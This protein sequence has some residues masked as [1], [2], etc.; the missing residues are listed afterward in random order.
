M[1]VFSPEDKGGADSSEFPEGLLSAMAVSL[2]ILLL[3][4][5]LLNVLR[6]R[7]TYWGQAETS[8]E[9]WFSIALHP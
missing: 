5:V 6:C 9:A 4:V 3:S 1:C 8:A 2:T 7:L